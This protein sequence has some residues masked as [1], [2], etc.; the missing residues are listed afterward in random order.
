MYPFVLHG[1]KG[2]NHNGIDGDD[3]DQDHFWSDGDGKRLRESMAYD[4]T[5]RSDY[6][7]AADELKLIHVS[8]ESDV[9]DD[10]SRDI[11]S[12]LPPWMGNKF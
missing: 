11:R 6:V 1:K 2:N 4:G 5:T 12:L 8:D 10:Y 3:D 7:S 9:D